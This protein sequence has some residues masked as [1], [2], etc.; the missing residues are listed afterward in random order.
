MSAAALL[1]FLQAAGPAV[2]ATV[3][4]SRVPVGDEVLYSVRVVSADAGAFR[5]ELPQI[6]GLLLAERTERVDE[7]RSGGQLTRAYQLEVRYRASQVGVWR[8]DPVLV[9]VGAETAVAPPVVVTVTNTGATEP[10][11]NPRVAELIRRV[12]GPTAGEPATLAVVVSKDR[13]YQGEQLDIVTGA[14]FS[15]SLRARLR[16]PPTLKP[17]VLAG[18]WSVPQPAVPGIVATRAVGEDVYDLFVSHQVAFPLT[19]GAV[20]VPPARLEY[21]VPLTRRASGDERAVDAT[22]N[23]V[24]IQVLPLPDPAPAGFH[25]PT[26]EQLKVTYSVRQLPA[27]AGEPLPVE[28]VVSGDGNLAFWL[29]PTVNWPAGTRAYLDKTDEAERVAGGLLGGTKTFRFLMIPDSV[30][31][32]ALPAVAYPF[33]DPGS[34]SYR[35]AGAPGMVVPVLPGRGTVRRK[36]PFLAP[37]GDVRLAL[38]SLPADRPLWWV[39]A[40]APLGA[41]AAAAAWRAR[42]RRPV[43]TKAPKLD[44]LAELEGLIGRLVPDADRG[45]IAGLERG[46]RRGGVPREPAAE[47]ARLKADADR[48][49]FT[50][51]DAS[52]VGALKQLLAAVLAKLPRLARGAGPLLVLVIAAAAAGQDAETPEQRYGQEAFGPAAEGFLAR[53]RG[54]RGRWQ[55]W[56]D[57]AAARYAEGNDAEAALFLERALG[58]APR[59]AAARALWNTLEREYEPLHGVR[60]R[61]GLTRGEVGTVALLG[62]WLALGAAVLV[63]RRRAWVVTIAAA[64]LA[65]LAFA[66]WW[67]PKGSRA[68]YLRAAMTLRQSPHGLAPEHGSL[69]ALTRVGLARDVGGWL[70]VRDRD[71]NQGWVPAGS[72]AGPDLVD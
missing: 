18:V 43:R 5:V 72:V 10:A 17:P 23:D 56:F 19:E 69:P 52:R 64:G 20:R 51:G 62:W 34:G 57:A 38:P 13:L 60:P 45:T 39:L 1:L 21:A 37:T 14:W 15:R 16:R 44:S 36:P 25:G 2:E 59:A 12:P 30:G 6:D 46:L 49:R 70:L 48:I 27:H 22:S 68:G 7:S 3:D 31:S 67:P 42:R 28:V 63:R 40:A 53:A 47:L 35:E 8:I 58:V 33:F 55:D 66:A 61:G 4:R 24:T 71:G 29:P 54:P 32:V 11:P 41:V 65:G 9:F 26:A 50:P